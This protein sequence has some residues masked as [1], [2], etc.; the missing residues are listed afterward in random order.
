MQDPGKGNLDKALGCPW[1]SCLGGTL[2]CGQTP[3][4]VLGP[5]DAAPHSIPGTG[6]MCS[7][8]VWA[9]SS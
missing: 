8:T 6:G 2:S 3:P 1:P 9:F 7:V 5:W 4:A